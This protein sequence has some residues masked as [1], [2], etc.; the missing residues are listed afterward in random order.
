[1][2]ILFLSAL[3]VGASFLIKGESMKIAEIKVSGTRMISS[4]E[5]ISL[6]DGSEGKRRGLWEFIFPKD[7]RFIYKNNEELSGMI[8]AHFPRV[9]EVAIRR[10]YGRRLISVAVSERKEEIV[11]C[12]SLNDVKNC[13]WIDNEG[14]VIGEAPDSEGSLVTLVEDKTNREILLGKE[15]VTKDKLKNLII[16][17]E[18]IKD[19]GWFAESIAIT[20]PLLKEAFIT[21]SSGQEIIVNIERSPL[22]EGKAILNAIISSGKWP[23]IE[24][25]DLRIEGKGFYKMK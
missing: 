20:D 13:F 9:K 8:I 1:M 19:F 17:S 15:A 7:H 10:D 11:W 16:A 5:I 25:V 24:Y 6:I 2:I 23:E 18:M 4:E 14:F 21:I 12:S 3:G 22:T